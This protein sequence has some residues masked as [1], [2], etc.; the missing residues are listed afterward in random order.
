MDS[1]GSGYGANRGRASSFNA[2][3]NNDRG[4]RAAALPLTVLSPALTSVPSL[5]R[6]GMYAD[7]EPQRQQNSAGPASD[8]VPRGPRSMGID[9]QM[10]NR[11][12]D[13]RGNSTSPATVGFGQSQQYRP[14][15]NEGAGNSF[16]ITQ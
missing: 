8:S 3:I 13:S 12:Y 16:D 14:Q 1:G 6:S 9:T 4:S 15:H 7:R 10:V 11:Q 2:P 5:A